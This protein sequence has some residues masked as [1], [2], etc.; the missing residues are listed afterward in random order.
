MS[1]VGR[2]AITAALLDESQDDLA[3]TALA[4]PRLT[5]S[6]AAAGWLQT[7]HFGVAKALQDVGLVTANVRF[8]GSSAGS[9]AAAALV[10]QCDMDDLCEYAV[11]CSIDCRS[12]LLNAFQ[13][14][15][16][17]RRGI[18]VFA[19]DKFRSDPSLRRAL[20]AQLEVYVS[21]LPWCR[22]KV[23]HCFSVVED[24]EEAL[25]ASCCLTPLAGMPF[26]LRRTGEIVCDGGLTAY[27]PRK[28]EHNVIAVSALYFNSAHIRPTTFVPAWWGLYPPG[29]KAYRAL[30]DLGY[31]DAIAFLV[32]A[33]HIEPSHLQRM[34]PTPPPPALTPFVLVVDA[35]AG[36]FFMICLRPCA[37]FFIYAELFLS[38][39]YLFVKALLLFTRQPWRDVY[40]GIRNVVSL[41]VLL[42]VL[43]GSHVPVNYQRLEKSSRLYRV[44]QPLLYR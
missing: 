29:E 5:F 14:R 6:F 12:S 9:L 43:L 33:K 30:Y 19:V 32:K 23:M 16:Y 11:R 41:R 35:V 2:E 3:H 7:Y 20:S 37:L 40:H 13:I 18:E 31:N 27:Q 17:V 38:T 25:V 22:Q 42:H 36:L 4:H 28:G 15:K 34:K 8:C 24:L 21:V 10:T 26:P 39:A 1:D 44:L